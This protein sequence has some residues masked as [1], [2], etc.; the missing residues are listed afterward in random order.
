MG[1]YI[2][3]NG[4]IS[5]MGQDTVN[6]LCTPRVGA[7]VYDYLD[8]CINRAEAKINSFAATRWATPLPKSANADEWAYTLVEFELWKN[9]GGSNTPDKYKESKEETMK[10]LFAMGQGFY[11]PIGATALE[12]STGDTGHSIATWSEPALFREASTK[13]W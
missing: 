10:E 9:G 11:E 5:R 8:D 2:N 1:N 4:V 13:Y 6:A 7:E 12:S 3:Y